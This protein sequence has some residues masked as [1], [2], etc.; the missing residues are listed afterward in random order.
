M[1][2]KKR[3][4]RRRTRTVQAPVLTHQ[5]PP[6][7]TSFDN[8]GQSLRCVNCEQIWNGPHKGETIKRFSTESKAVEDEARRNGYLQGGIS[9][10]VC[11]KRSCIEAFHRKTVAEL[12]GMYGETGGDFAE[13]EQRM[14]RE[15]F[16]EVRRD[17]DRYPEGLIDDV[18][19]PL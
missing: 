1:A 19:P 12:E 14:N 10:G 11:N 2:D 16:E 8:I 9:D 15:Q 17:K 7:Q 4:K 18:E 5:P 3:M 6:K 13:L